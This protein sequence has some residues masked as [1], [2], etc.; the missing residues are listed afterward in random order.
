MSTGFLSSQE[1]RGRFGNEGGNKKRM[2][3]SMT[4]RGII[5]GRTRRDGGDY[6]TREWGKVC[7]PGAAEGEVVE[8][9]TES[10]TD[11]IRLP[12]VEG[13]ARRRMSVA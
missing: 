12:C 3:T 5:E 9:V 1:G 11:M 6:P 8:T 10:K 13:K 4:R 7:L 2:V